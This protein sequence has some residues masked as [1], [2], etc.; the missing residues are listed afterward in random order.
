MTAAT[1]PALPPRHLRLLRWKRW[2]LGNTLVVALGAVVVSLLLPNWYLSQASVFPPERPGA[3]RALLTGQ[4]SGRLSMSLMASLLGG[5]AF[6]IP[7]FASPSDIMARILNSR[8]LREELIRRFDLIRHFEVR[9][10][11]QALKVLAERMIVYVGRDGFVNVSFLDTDPQLAADVA[12]EAVRLMDEIQRERRHTVA[13][14]AREFIAQ[15]LEETRRNLAA[16]EESLR[17]FQ[18]RTGIV[19]PEDQAQALVEV[20]YQ[21]LG[22]RLALEVER[23]ALEQVAGP[24]VPRLARIAA[25]IRVLDE[26]LRRLGG[27]AAPDSLEEP[28][29]AGMSDLMLEYRRRLREVRVQEALHEYLITQHE[30]YRIQEVRDTPT[31]QVLDEARPAEEKEKPRRSIICIVATLLAFA[32]SLLFFELL[33]RLRESAHRDGPASRMVEGLGGG[34]LVRRLRRTPVV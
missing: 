23:E 13:Q 20:V 1:P 25:D 32:G 30:Y 16:A 10:M 24:D 22:R 8:T 29:L 14:T 26:A 18:Q 4:P 21:L 12:N 34:W 17:A 33:E 6:D 3:T 9:N 15:R 19:A 5:S 27:S 7:L 31:V 28:S 11:D 2:I